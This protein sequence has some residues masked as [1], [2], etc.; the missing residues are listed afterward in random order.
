MM[1]TSGTLRAQDEF[2]TWREAVLQ[3]NA[4]A[5]L[6]STVGKPRVLWS[7]DR[8]LVAYSYRPVPMNG[9]S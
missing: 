6:F 5:Q 7:I 1:S 4:R 2:F 8:W 9:A 3:A